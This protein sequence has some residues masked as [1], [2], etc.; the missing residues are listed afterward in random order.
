MGEVRCECKHALAFSEG[1]RESCARSLVPEPHK[2]CFLRACDKTFLGFSRVGAMPLLFHTCHGRTERM[3]GFS[4]L[5]W[6]MRLQIAAH[7]RFLLV[8]LAHAVTD[9]D[10][11]I[12]TQGPLLVFAHSVTARCAATNG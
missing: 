7:G 8:T 1:L 3:A 5:R 11:T 9:R 4:L 10:R 6:P 12:F 2:F